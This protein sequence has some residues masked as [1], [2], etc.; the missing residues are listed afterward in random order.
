MGK[1][2]EKVS[3]TGCIFPSCPVAKN[4]GVAKHTIVFQ[5]NRGKVLFKLGAD[6]YEGLCA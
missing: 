3:T 4:T 5:E 1:F 2:A 6:R